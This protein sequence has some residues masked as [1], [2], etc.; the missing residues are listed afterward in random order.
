LAVGVDSLLEELLILTMDPV[1]AADCLPDRGCIPRDW[2]MEPAAGGSA[3]CGL[4]V[5]G[6]RQEIDS[7]EVRDFIGPDKLLRA[8]IQDAKATQQ[9]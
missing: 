7:Q 2:P 4:L 5:G 6:L 1:Q 3:A 8:C 9:L